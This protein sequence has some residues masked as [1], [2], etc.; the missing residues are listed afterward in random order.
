MECVAASLANFLFAPVK[1]SFTFSS[2]MFLY[3]SSNS[4][5]L[6]FA[7]NILLQAFSISV[8]VIFFSANNF[9]RLPVN[10]SLTISISTP[11]FKASSVTFSFSPNPCSVISL[12]DV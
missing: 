9:F 11:A 8:S 7:D 2:C 4:P 1:I 6:Y 10:A 12:M 3:G 5:N